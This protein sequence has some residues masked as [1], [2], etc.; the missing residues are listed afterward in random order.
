MKPARILLFLYIL[1]FML[2]TFVAKAAG[3]KITDAEAIFERSLQSV[4]VN[5]QA[6]LLFRAKY[7]VKNGIM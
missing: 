7:G 6:I 5:T 4:D 2:V 1:L 3:I